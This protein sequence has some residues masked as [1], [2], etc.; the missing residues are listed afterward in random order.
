MSGHGSDG[1]PAGN[2]RASRNSPEHPVRLSRAGTRH[3]VAR[4]APR[5][6]DLALYAGGPGGSGHLRGTK[7]EPSDSPRA[8]P[9]AG[10]AAWIYDEFQPETGN[11][12]H[13]EDA[14]SMDDML[15]AISRC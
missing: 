8:A 15:D 4:T 14:L 13:A 12:G 7:P 11:H 3:L 10:Q 6:G 2:L 9:R 1:D 5:R